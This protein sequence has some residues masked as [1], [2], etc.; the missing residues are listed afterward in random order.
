MSKRS[1]LDD[2]QA[3]TLNKV[4]KRSKECERSLLSPIMRELQ[5]YLQQRGLM[6]QTF[7]ELLS[8]TPPMAALD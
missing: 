3:W 5:S 7:R 2:A 6:F 1:E 4:G 8:K